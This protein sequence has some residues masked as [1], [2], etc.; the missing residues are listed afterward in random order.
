[1]IRAL[2]VILML[3]WLSGVG[4]GQTADSGLQSM[5]SVQDGRGWE[6]VGRLHIGTSGFCT[7]SLISATTVLTAAHCLFDPATGQRVGDNTLEFRAGYRQGRA[8]AYRGVRRSVVHP[9]YSYGAPSSPGRVASDLALIELDQPIRKSNVLPFE[10]QAFV[11]AGSIVRVVSYARGRAEAPSLQESC[12]V[13]GAQDHAQVLSCDVDFG[14]SGAPIFAMEGQRARI[15]SVVS[16]KAEMDGG[17][18]ALAASVRDGLPA[19]MKHFAASDGVFSR[20]MP[21]VQTIN[22]STGLAL[23]GAKFVKP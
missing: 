8:A 22:R 9:D 10:T 5:D 17:K 23:S 6:A 21:Q 2:L 7:A 12:R 3:F 20:T 16:A 4:N 18:V 1:M 13:L 11:R 14:S 19:L 15:V